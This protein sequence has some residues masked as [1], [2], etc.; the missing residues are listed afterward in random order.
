MSQGLSKE[1][2]WGCQPGRGNSWCEARM[3]S[4]HEP[5]VF[6]EAEEGHCG[7][8]KRERQGL[9]RGPVAHRKGFGFSGRC[10]KKIDWENLK[11]GNYL[12]EDYSDVRIRTGQD[13]KAS[14][15]T[16]AVLT[17]RSH[18][19]GLGS[20]CAPVLISHATT[21]IVICCSSRTRL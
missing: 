5:S 20:F 6:P 7:L 17:Q 16:T 19:G 11:Q 21:R 3:R 12:L 9:G 1:Q 15:P 13:W 18:D 4:A 2:L 8:G 14:W 10:G